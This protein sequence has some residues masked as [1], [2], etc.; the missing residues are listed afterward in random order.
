MKTIQKQKIGVING[1]EVSRFT[2]D[3]GYIKFSALNYGCV[4][5][6]INTP[7]RYGAFENVVLGFGDDLEKYQTDSPYF[8]SIVGRCAGRISKSS[9]ELGGKTYVLPANER[10]NHLHGGP[11]GFS[12]VVWN[13]DVIDEAIVFT[14]HSKAM[15]MGYPG[16]VDV[17]VS[18]RLIKNELI[19]EYEA[20]VD[21]RTPINMTNHSYFNLS[22]N[23]K[24]TVHNHKLTVPSK[25]VLELNKE[26]LPTGEFIDVDGT[27][28]DLQAGRYLNEAFE[29]TEEQI[30]I[31]EQGFDHPFELEEGLIRLEDEKSGRILTIET[32]QP[33]VVVYTGNQL[34]EGQFEVNGCP[35]KRYHGV[36]LE[37]Q[38]LPDAVNHEEFPSCIVVPEKSYFSK[39][40]YRFDTM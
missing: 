3:N 5:T 28:F 9:F 39:T 15:E 33:A 36:C 12:E 19:A 23:A 11:L 10:H 14:Y 20:T 38:G 6:E 13:G 4:I 21:E 32:S 29:S 2:L 7:N 17:T 40:T 30:Q 16:N 24:E 18:Y 34:V 22:G 35:V 8:G 1:K 37:T 31:V 26:S 27:V 25:R